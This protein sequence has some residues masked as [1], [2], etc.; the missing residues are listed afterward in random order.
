MA[1]NWWEKNRNKAIIAALP[2]L[3]VVAHLLL[4]WGE[5]GGEVLIEK[6]EEYISFIILLT[7]LFVISGGTFVQGSLT[8]TPLGNSGIMACSPGSS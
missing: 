1:D 5:A 2:S 4:T 8:G 7:A 3:P 6:I